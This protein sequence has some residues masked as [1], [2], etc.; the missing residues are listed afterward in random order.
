MS[1]K[2]KIFIGLLVFA[3]IVAFAVYK[4]ANKP[5]D[6]L[7]NVKATQNYQFAELMDKT[8]DTA[9]LSK[10]KEC[11]ICVNGQVKKIDKDSSSITI[12]LGDT[13]STSS[14]ICQID[15]RHCNEFQSVKEGDKIAIKGKMAGCTI[16]EDLGLGNTIE[17]NFCTINN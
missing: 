17:M 15:Q 14:V 10:L 2:L 8:S 13:V 11:V 4:Y 6:D 1:K 7:A 3:L 12:E 9:S 16:D 5:N